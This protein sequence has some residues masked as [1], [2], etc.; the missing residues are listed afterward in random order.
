MVKKQ[1]THLATFIIILFY[2]SG[3]QAQESVIYLG[4][5]D[6][7]NNVQLTNLSLIEGKRG[8]LDITNSDNE[9]IA[10][11][12]SD[13]ILH[14]NNPEEYDETG[15]YSFLSQVPI[16][17]AEN[18]FG[19][20]SAYFDGTEP[21]MI[22]PGSDSLFSP[23]SLWG[24]FSL[25]FRIL[26]ATLKEGS[27]IFL[28][29]GLQMRE[30]HLIPQEIRCSISNRQLVWD[31]ENFFINPDNSAKRISLSGDQLIPGIWSHH[32]I[33]FN[34]KTG[35]LEYKIN[36]VPADIIYTSKSGRESVEFNIPHIG[37]QQSFPIELG[38]NFS[39]LID[40]F[41]ISKVI[42]ETPALNRY[43]SAGYLETGIIDMKVPNSLLLMIE[44]ESTLPANTAIKYQYAISNDKYK[45]STP[46]ISWSDFIPSSPIEVRGR[47][48]KIKSQL[49]AE[50]AEEKAPVLNS[51]KI[52]FR[53][54][55]RPSPPLDISVKR[56]DQNIEVRWTK[57]IN[58]EIEGYLIYYGE[59]PGQYFAADSPIDSG[60]SN[61]IVLEGLDMNKRYYIAVTSY[62]SL[63]PRLESVFSR[64]ISISP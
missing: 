27:T 13:M 51:L 26:P 44:A 37:N 34:S 59:E 57:S 23:S 38:E 55:P 29:K 17:K 6:L 62:K 46:D 45:L 3:L 28:W 61:F 14:L 50:P 49:Y 16:I 53:E 41:R 33:T 12:F 54:T 18:S 56:I 8:F 35:L 36:N 32:M 7:W 1:I 2:C 24:D 58:P 64:E 4:E 31:F 25:E 60:N 5:E 30:N 63:Y 47:Y 39:G 43:S 11:K 20:G 15:N 48:I 52:F 22:E 40:E 21:L 19:N 9:Y 10:D 42:V